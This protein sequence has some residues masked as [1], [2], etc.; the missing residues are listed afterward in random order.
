MP[1]LLLEVVERLAVGLLGRLGWHAARDL[2]AGEQLGAWVGL[3]G[4]G[5]G[6][7]LARVRG[8]G[9]AGGH[10]H[11]AGSLELFSVGVVELLLL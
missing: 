8:A 1:D 10:L 5:V 11:L 7:C 2:L 6:V 4:V 3:L 9:E